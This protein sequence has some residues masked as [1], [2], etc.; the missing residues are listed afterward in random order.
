MTIRLALGAALA[1]FAAACSQ[2]QVP[3][4]PALWEVSGPDGQ[5]GYLFGTIHALP[6][7]VDWQS[8]RI[9]AALERADRLVLE[10]RQLDDSAAMQAIFTRLARTPG[11]PPL[12]A[13]VGAPY[14][15]AL[16]K[17]MQ[18]AGLKEAQF[19]DVETWAAALTLAQAVRGAADGEGVD[20][21]LMAMAGTKPVEELEGTARQLGLFDALPE[22]EQRDLLDAVV[23]E[24]ASAA[25]NENR[26]EGYWRKGDMAAIARETGRGMLADP[27]L[28]QALLV[29]RNTAWADRVAAML[30]ARQRPFVAVGAAHMAGDEGLPALLAQRGYTVRR[31]Q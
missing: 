2:P 24:A 19:A 4:T 22:E 30:Q 15:E 8:G 11:Q 20:R 7:H 9:D 14:R 13:K 1:L 23:A 17:L 25:S 21:A 26:I 28:R 16:A 29:D 18:Q 6:A 10:I 5:H 12:S 31:V 27:E 3:A